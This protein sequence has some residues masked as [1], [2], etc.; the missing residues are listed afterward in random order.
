MTADVAVPGYGRPVVLAC[1]Q[2]AAVALSADDVAALHRT[3]FA[4]ICRA[5]A[6]IVGDRGLAE[7]VAQDAF[8]Q[9]YR[10]RDKVRED[11]AVGYVRT[12]ALNRAKDVAKNRARERDLVDS[13]TRLGLVPGDAYPLL[14]YRPVD[15]AADLWHLRD[16]IAKLPYEQRVVVV[17]HYFW[18]MPD[19]ET[20]EM[21]GVPAVTVRSRLRRA[22]LALMR[23]VERGE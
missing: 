4:D 12:I 3:H 11:T 20:A 1:A 15:R 21:L 6:W 8:L 9:T 22:R 10:N 16:E 23:T 17:A 14:S 18:D 7:E 5:V 19:Q 13:G 2:G